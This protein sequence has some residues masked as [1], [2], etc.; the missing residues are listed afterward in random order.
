MSRPLGAKKCFKDTGQNLL[1]NSKCTEEKIDSLK[2]R[3]FKFYGGYNKVDGY[4]K[5]KWV[6]S[7][8]V[9]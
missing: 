2:Q 7:N 6:S 3:F 4:A 9:C 5:N 1:K 8:I